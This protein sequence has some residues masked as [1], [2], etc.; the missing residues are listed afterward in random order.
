MRRHIL[1]ILAIG[2]VAAGLSLLLLYETRE[3]QA[4]AG[5]CIR[6][7]LVLG[8]F[9]LA[10]PQLQV[11]LVRWPPWLLGCLAL[12]GLVI[13]AQPKLILYVGALLA[14]IA[15][16]QFFSRFLKPPARRR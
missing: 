7:G 15:A 10:W 2:L 16:L 9:W 13:L 6:V 11:L 3:N 12:G 4:A 1:G 14:I 8:A 5:F